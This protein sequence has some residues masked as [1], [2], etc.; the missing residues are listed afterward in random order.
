MRGTLG[1]VAALGLSFAGTA[2]G[3]KE[4]TDPPPIQFGK[5]APGGPAQRTA[6][7]PAQPPA[8]Q[9]P[10]AQPPAATPDPGTP[11]PTSPGAPPPDAGAPAPSDAGVQDAGGDAAAPDAGGGAQQG[12]LARCQSAAQTCALP[13]LGQ[14]P[15]PAKC[16]AAFESCRK[17]CF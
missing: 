1:I 2:C 13:K 14:L 10:P 15:D 11:A 5:Q 16:Q 17:A 7:P 9:P 8:A 12:C 4:E 3:S 6:A